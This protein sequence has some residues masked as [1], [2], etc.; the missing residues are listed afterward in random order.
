[1]LDARL[2]RRRR[3]SPQ[4]AIEGW[5]LGM[6]VA[7]G[8]AAR[9]LGG[10]RRRRARRRRP[11]STAS[12]R[13][14]RSSDRRSSL[15]V[16]PDH[17]ILL[18]GL[19]EGHRF[20]TV[21]TRARPPGRSRA[22][23]RGPLRRGAPPR[24]PRAHDRAA[25]LGSAG[26]L[27]GAVER[28]S[29]VADSAVLEDRAPAA[30]RRVGKRGPRRDRRR[31]A[32]R[33][34]AGAPRAGRRRARRS[35]ARLRRRLRAR[36]RGRPAGHDRD[37]RAS[38]CRPTTRRS[39]TRSCSARAAQVY[40]N[41]ETLVLAYPDWQDA[42]RS[43]DADERTALHVFTLPAG[44]PHDD[45][46]RLGIRSRLAALAVRDRRQ[47]RDRAAWRHASRARRAARPSRASSRR[48]SRTS[49]RRRSARHPNLA[50]GE[51]LFGARFL[52]DRAY[53]VTFRQIDPLFVIDLRGSRRIRRCSAR[54]SCR[55]SA[56]TST[57]SAITTS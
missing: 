2:P 20:A 53:L 56:S 46:P 27:P 55:A 22:L 9:P 35:S 38:T 48:G 8:R 47:G 49:A 54:W 28:R 24:Q 39:P 25:R 14:F 12:A 40:A 10:L 1:M 36:D 11:L 13:R 15:A 30:H 52:G 29:D 3:R 7:G 50:P 5:P 32:R 18:L 6:F 45:V 37:R 26:G 16:D 19:R 51:R 34:A 33:L 4:L 41:G 31:R 17:S 57:R 23:R 44:L 42:R 21:A 43:S